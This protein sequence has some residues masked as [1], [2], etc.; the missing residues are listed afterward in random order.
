MIRVLRAIATVAA[1][2]AWID[3][4]VAGRVLASYRDH[5]PQDPVD[6]S[7]LTD[8]ELRH[9]SAAIVFAHNHHL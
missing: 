5:L 4:Q 9:R 7:V 8:R 6:L 3:P 1:G 2:D